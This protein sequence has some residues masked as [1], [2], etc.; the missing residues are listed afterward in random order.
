[1][2]QSEPSVGFLAES[3]RQGPDKKIRRFVKDKKDLYDFSW[4]PA[5]QKKK[6]S[7]VEKRENAE[8]I[9]VFIL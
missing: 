6:S 9:T 5:S 4:V 3:G 7:F 8:M 2:F 1:L